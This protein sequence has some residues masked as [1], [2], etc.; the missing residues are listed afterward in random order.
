MPGLGGLAIA[1][2][3]RASGSGSRTLRLAERNIADR[4]NKFPNVNA[5]T[6]APGY[7]EGLGLSMVR[8]REFAETDG[9][10]GAEAA[11]VNQSFANK[12]WPDEDVIG[13]QIKLSDKDDAT[14]VKVV[15]VSPRIL[16]SGG[17]PG[18]QQDMYPPLVY[19]PFRQ[20]PVATF[21]M[22]IRSNVPREKLTA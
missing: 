5:L 7:F 16:Q 19:I 8:G 18:Q 17:G 14:W 6:I 13:K 22:M 1:T 20:D 21:S 12:Y 9:G 3:P 15:G 10:A 4:E 11:V 2:V